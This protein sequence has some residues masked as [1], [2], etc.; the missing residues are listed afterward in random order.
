MLIG[1]I[2]DT[3][4]NMPLIARAVDYFNRRGVALV[5]HAGDLISPI[6]AKEFTRLA[7]P[8]IAVFGN[9]DGERTLWRERIKGWGEVHERTFEDTIEGKRVLLMH[10]PQCLEALAKSQMYDVI[11]YG[12]T[13]RVDRRS[14]GKTLI[15]NPGE[16]GAWLTGKSTIAVLELPSQNVEIVDL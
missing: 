12:H 14:E 10:E 4:E 5:L 6:M 11:V 8:M 2:S 3:H 1:L 7:V 13:H 9:N 15:V 16:C